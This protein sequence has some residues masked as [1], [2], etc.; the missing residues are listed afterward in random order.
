MPKIIPVGAHWAICQ[1]VFVI[2]WAHLE[3]PRGSNYLLSVTKKYVPSF[4][5]SKSGAPKLPIRT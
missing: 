5:F 4:I 3:A 2:G 1:A